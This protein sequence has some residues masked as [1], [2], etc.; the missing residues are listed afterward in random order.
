MAEEGEE[1]VAGP[2]TGEWQFS[3]CFW[4]LGGGFRETRFEFVRIKP[5]IS[6]WGVQI[7]VSVNAGVAMSILAKKV[8]KGVGDR[9]AEAE[10]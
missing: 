10:T 4:F 2:D 8:T 9:V 7:I 6:C 1:N 3:F 5:R